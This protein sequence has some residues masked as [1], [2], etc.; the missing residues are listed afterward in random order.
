MGIVQ[1]YKGLLI[2]RIFLGV[3]GKHVG[4]DCTLHESNGKADKHKQRPDYTLGL[5]TISLCGIADTKCS[6]GRP[7]FSVL[8]ALQVLSPACWHL[9]LQ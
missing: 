1:D 3:A 2:A 8:P 6:L 5:H 4:L 9:L 7:C